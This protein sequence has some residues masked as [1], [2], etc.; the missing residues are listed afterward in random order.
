M[1]REA[2]GSRR[3]LL[4][5]GSSTGGWI[6][7]AK[8]GHPV[9]THA[10]QSQEL[11]GGVT[12]KGGVA[13]LAEL[14]EG[15]HGGQ[16]AGLIGQRLECDVDQGLHAPVR[17]EQLADFKIDTA[18]SQDASGD[19]LQSH[20]P[21]PQDRDRLA[22]RSSPHNLPRVV[23]ADLSVASSAMLHDRPVSGLSDQIWLLAVEKLLEDLRD[24]FDSVEV[25]ELQNARPARHE[26]PQ[27]QGG[28]SSTRM[29][30]VIPEEGQQ[31]LNPVAQ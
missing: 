8:E 20:V 12:L 11:Y 18:H 6:S 28:F 10:L 14:G 5:P 2:Y 4:L 9:R 15:A 13:L 27:T 17:K 24:D 26:R 1:S 25:N 22:K 29:V 23:S 7:R 31:R 16:D 3:P 30:D 19:S 21:V